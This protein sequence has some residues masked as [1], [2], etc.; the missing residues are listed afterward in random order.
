MPSRAIV[1]VKE[2][3]QFKSNEKVIELIHFTSWPL[4]DLDFLF[5]PIASVLSN[6]LIL[7]KILDKPN[8]VPKVLFLTASNP[9]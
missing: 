1:V 7:Q 4:Q 8:I 5:L 6:G 3:V 9:V 2:K